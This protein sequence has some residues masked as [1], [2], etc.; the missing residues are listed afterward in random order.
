MENTK[1]D[2]EIARLKEA[3]A[4]LKKQNENKCLNCRGETIRKR[5][6]AE[7]RSE[8]KREVL[9]EIEG[10]M[11]FPSKRILLEKEFFEWLGKR[12]FPNPYPKGIQAKGMKPDI[13][14]FLCW[15]MSEKL[16]QLR[17]QADKEAV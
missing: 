2:A 6:K 11:N 16:A 5:I 7:A 4:E 15:F 3:N 10:I 9:D 13:Y 17:A 14:N 12:S 1:V 8:G